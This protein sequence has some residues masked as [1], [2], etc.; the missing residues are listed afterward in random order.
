MVKNRKSNPKERTINGEIVRSAM[1]YSTLDGIFAV[2][3]T[4]LTTGTLLIGFLLV[5]GASASE[6][7]L[8]AMLPL[9]SGVLQPI[10]AA[11]VRWQNGW[12]KMVTIIGVLIDDFLW[13]AVLTITAF[14]PP[15]KVVTGIIGILIIQQTVTAFY[16]VSWTSWISDLVPGTLRGRFFG[17]RNFICNALGAVSAIV[18]GQFIERIGHNAVWSFGIV[19]AVAMIS[20]IISAFFLTRQP[21]PFPE[22]VSGLYFAKQISMPFQDLN[23]RKYLN[24]SLIWGLGVQI[25]SPFFTVYMIRDLHIDFGT[26]TLFAGITTFANLLGQRYWGPLC[27]RF[28]NKAVMRA[29]GILIVTLPFWWLFASGTGPGFYLIGVLSA[30]GGFAWAGYLLANGNF[31]MVLSPDAGKTSYFAMQAAVAGLFGAIGSLGGGLLIDNVLNK[32]PDLAIWLPRGIPMLFFISFL[33][34]FI[35]WYY[36][37]NIKEP[38][39]KPQMQVTYLIRDAVRTFNIL[40]GFSPLLHMPASL[41]YGRNRGIRKTPP[42]KIK[43]RDK[44]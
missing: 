33:I 28:G 5:L 32:I 22:D 34:R 26:V 15:D 13:S 41:I 10:G 7:G 6:I 36:L 30:F 12:R 8:V 35:A 23:Y 14:L 4:T 25:A 1:R 37:K 24:F 39:R 27:D 16:V 42:H 38:A 11:L 19:I 9:L 2:Q 20:R 40:Q 21:E 29:T 3:Y 44:R 43:K 18:A 17:K 31:M